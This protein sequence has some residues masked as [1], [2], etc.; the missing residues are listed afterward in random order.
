MVGFLLGIQPE[1]MMTPIKR[2]LSIDF[3]M[4]HRFPIYFPT[5]FPRIFRQS[6]GLSSGHSDLPPFLR[7]PSRLEPS[8]SA[9]RVAAPGASLPLRQL[10][11]LEST[12]RLGSVASSSTSIWGFPKMGLPLLM[13]G[14]CWEK[15]HLE[16]DD[17]NG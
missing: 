7:G 3:L 1:K 5:I 2:H 9:P 10:L 14:F 8:S 13:D 12:M 6:P 11:R 17:F 15:S 4:F 16:M